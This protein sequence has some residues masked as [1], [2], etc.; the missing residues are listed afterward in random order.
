MLDSRIETLMKA[1]IS[2]KIMM[3]SMRRI[4]VGLAIFLMR[5]ESALVI[6]AFVKR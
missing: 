2:L 6:S 1:V 4:R 3:A 5:R